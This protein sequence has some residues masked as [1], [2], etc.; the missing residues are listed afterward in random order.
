[1]ASILLV[2]DDD[3]LRRILTINL[4]RRG[5]TVAEADSVKTALEAVKAFPQPFDVIVLDIYLPEGTGWD[6]LRGLHRPEPADGSHAGHATRVI[7]TTAVRP[8][9]CRLDEFHPDAVLVK[10]FPIDAL[11]RLIERVAPPET[12]AATG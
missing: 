8:A 7:V 9:Q 11:T 5:Y 6:V 4:A 2:E 10:P 3:Q 12:A 1:M